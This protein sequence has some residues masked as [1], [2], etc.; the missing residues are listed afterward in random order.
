MPRDYKDYLFQNALYTKI[1]SWLNKIFEKVVA[2]LL[3]LMLFHYTQ[4]LWG[5]LA[6]PAV[7]ILFSIKLPVS[8]QQTTN[9]TTLLWIPGPTVEKKL[10]RWIL[11]GLLHSCCGFWIQVLS[12]AV[13]LWVLHSSYDIYISVEPSGAKTEVKQT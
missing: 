8:K 2:K 11:L 4:H 9:Q 5:A 1:N 10:E 3:R 7:V 12:F 13:V 6:P